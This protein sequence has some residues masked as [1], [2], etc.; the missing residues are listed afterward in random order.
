[1][2]VALSFDDGYMGHM[3]IARLLSRLG[4]KATFFV[5]THLKYFEGKPLLTINDE[6]IAELS[7]LGHEVASHTCTHRVLVDLSTDELKYE[8]KESRR[9]LEDITGKEVLGLAYPYGIYNL[10]VIKIVKDYYYYARATDLFVFDDPLNINFNRYRIGAVGLRSL[11]KLLLHML[12]PHYRGKIKPVIFIHNIKK[13]RLLLLI[14]IL[15][16]LGVSF[17]TL[18][19][20]VNMVSSI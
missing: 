8:L 18:K 17:I 10:R 1:M 20:L 5:I 12:N 2:I 3:E 16:L 19:D 4:I 14:D 15:K 6:L 13:S 9:Y 7:A 11:H